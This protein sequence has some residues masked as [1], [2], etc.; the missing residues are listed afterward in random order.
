MIILKNANIIKNDNETQVKTVVIENDRIVSVIEDF[1]KIKVNSDDEIIDCTNKLLVPSFIDP[2]VH[3]REPGYE[4]KE[5]I[6]TGTRAALKGGYTKIFA[7]PNTRPVPDN[8]E[9]INEIRELSKKDAVIDVEFFS[10]LSIG[11]QGRE[12]VDIEAIS[13]NKIIGFTDD[14]RGLQGNSMMLESMKRIEKKNSIISAHTEDEA[15]LYKG[16]ITEGKYSKENGH[17]GILNAVEDVQIGRDLILAD[18]TGCRY[19][20]CHMSTKRGANL[21][22][23][24]QKW[25]AKVSG[26]VAPHHLLLNEDDLRDDGN[27]KMNP[28]LRTKEDNEALIDALKRGVI[29]CIATDH[30]PHSVEEKSKGL[31]N[32][33]FG[34]VGLEN[35]FSILY[36]YLVRKNKLTLETIVNAMGKNVA[37]VFNLEEKAVEEG[38]VADLTLID[39]EKEYEINVNNFESKGRNTPFDN[40]KVYGLIDTVIHRGKIKMT[41]G[42]ING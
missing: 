7:M 11:E 32:S 21:L 36:T 2:H 4:H 31:E 24:G 29:K 38:F 33:P 28:P 10:S 15:I 22:E 14:G 16:Y 41:G 12:L 27:Y 5:T 13:D 6:I 23:L 9:T 26:E 8:V 40:W 39:L 25:G 37:Q 20:I 18:T 35:S 30:A 17:R 3:L 1:S 42:K 19:H 34:I